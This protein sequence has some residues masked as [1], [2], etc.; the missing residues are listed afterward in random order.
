[1]RTLLLLAGL[2][3][4]LWILKAAHAADGPVFQV[5]GIQTPTFCGGLSTNPA[6]SKLPRDADALYVLCPGK[7]EPALTIKGCVKPGITKKDSM[8]SLS[9]QSWKQYVLVPK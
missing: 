3:L 6:C 9:C 1:M 7:A 4:S 5:C 2:F 8:Y